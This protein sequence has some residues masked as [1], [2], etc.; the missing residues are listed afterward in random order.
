MKIHEA[1][2]MYLLTR[3]CVRVNLVSEE[4]RVFQPWGEDDAKVGTADGL[5]PPRR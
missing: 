3:V 4:T 2:F 5:C 1:N